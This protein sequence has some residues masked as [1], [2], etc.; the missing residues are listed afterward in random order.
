M[1]YEKSEYERRIEESPV[2]SLDKKQEQSR[3][4]REVLKLVEYL[5]C[6][7]MTTNEAKYEPYGLEI[8]EVAKR[9]IANFDSSTGSF[10]H[11]FKSAWKK[12][13]GHLV[14]RELVRE[15]F[16]GIHFTEEQSR[17]YR[18]YM[19]LAQSMGQ[20]SNSADFDQKIAEAMGFTMAEVKSLK[21]MLACK[22]TRDTVLNVEKKEY[23][24]LNQLD[25]GFYTDAGM[26]ETETVTAYLDVI[27]SVFDRL[28]ARQK[29]L[30]AKLITA[31]L[32]LPLKDD[33][34]LLTA[35]Q[36]KSYYDN[37]IFK[38][39]LT[40]GAMIEAKEISHLLGIAESSTSR[41]WRN[42]KEKLRSADL[43]G[44]QRD[45]F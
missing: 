29:P 36:S 3:Y 18:K 10:L 22:P 11:Y 24:L 35:L 31:R 42:F 1:Y 38:K 16:A 33:P 45:E 43:Q 34:L 17:N 26:M 19:K 37:E 40:R 23:N 25:S 6:L 13:Y 30:L 4:K 44:R 20:G 5:Y 9:C 27:Q 2:F 41:S 21:E 32:S 39:C 8:V 15:D 28:Q 14:G 7:L 12:E